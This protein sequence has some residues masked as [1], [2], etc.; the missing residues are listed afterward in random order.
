MHLSTKSI[1]GVLLAALV[2][3]VLNVAVTLAVLDRN[4][5]LASPEI[6]SLSAADM[7]VG[8]VAAQDPGLSQ[9]D[10]EARIRVLNA[11]LDSAIAAFAAERGIIVVNSAAVLGGARD[12]TPELLAALGLSR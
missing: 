7:V 1:L 12:V 2:F 3:T 5:L 6:V 11:N 8:F 10:L 4:G 9:D